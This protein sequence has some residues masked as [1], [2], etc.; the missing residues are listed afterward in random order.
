M[1]TRFN[2]NVSQE[3]GAALNRPIAGN[4]HKGLGFG[5]LPETVQ[6]LELRVRVST[7]YYLYTTTVNSIPK[8]RTLLVIYSKRI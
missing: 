7:G 4:S 1:P 6:E 8:V 5:K 2:D 3:E